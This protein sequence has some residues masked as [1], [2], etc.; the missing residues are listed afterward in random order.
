MTN[1]EQDEFY[2]HKRVMHGGLY[3]ATCSTCREL[4]H[5]LVAASKAKAG[6]RD[7]G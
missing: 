7:G 3:V 4:W 5:A 2:D 6:V 1:R